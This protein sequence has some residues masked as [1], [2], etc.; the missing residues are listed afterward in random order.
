MLPDELEHQ[1]FVEIRVQQGP[2]NRVEF[3][4]VVVR[5]L[6][7]VDDH[8]VLATILC[9]LFEKINRGYLW[10]AFFCGWADFRK[11]NTVISRVA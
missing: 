1:Q 7:E 2:G 5:P 9:D 4:V 10:G 8:F 6:G 11:A 3:P